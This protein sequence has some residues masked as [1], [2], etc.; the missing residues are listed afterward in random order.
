MTVSSTASGAVWPHC[1]VRTDRPQPTV[2]AWSHGW[3]F[4][5]NLHPLRSPL[6]NSKMQTVVASSGC[7]H[8]MSCRVMLVAG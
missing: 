8:Q 1:C 7:V 5:V 3:G 6:Y 2:T 4:N